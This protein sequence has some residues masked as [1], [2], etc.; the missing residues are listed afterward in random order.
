[1]PARCVHPVSFP[2]PADLHVCPTCSLSLI[3][4]KNEAQHDSGKAV[5]IRAKG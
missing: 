2:A 5:R 1:M 4:G 3:N